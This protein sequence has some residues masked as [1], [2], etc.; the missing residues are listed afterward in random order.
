MALKA[1]YVLER[2]NWV[3][4]DDDSTRWS[5]NELIDW[6]NDAQ[7]A[8]QVLRPDSTED[9]VSVELAPGAYQSLTALKEQLLRPGSKIMK[10]ARN[11]S[12]NG[13]F[14]TVR[15]VSRQIMDAVRPGWQSDQP[16]IDCVNY[17]TDVN[18]PDVFWVWPP[19]P[20]PSPTQPAMMVELYYSAAIQR[21][22]NLLVAGT[23]RDVVGDLS[24][25]DRFALPLVD[26]VLYRAF[27]KDAEYG[28]SGARSKT[29]F[30]LFQSA[31]MADVQ[32]TQVAQPKAKEPTM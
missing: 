2:V 3:L 32:G 29:H 23:W 28:G 9:I 21:I 11:M 31:L 10:V 16:S 1:T 30:D 24:V 25:A 17:M 20:V 7:E 14:R 18:L 13:R 22:D 26:Y 19:A 15:L 8:T 4:Q 12:L 6:L 5:A 27:M